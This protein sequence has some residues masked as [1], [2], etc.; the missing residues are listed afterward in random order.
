L[1]EADTRERKDE[2]LQFFGWESAPPAS[3]RQRDTHAAELDI[4]LS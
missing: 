1:G 3:V 2:V 4:F